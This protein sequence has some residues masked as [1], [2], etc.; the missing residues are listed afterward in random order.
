[1]I[2]NACICI[3]LAILVSCKGETTTTRHIE[4]LSDRELKMLIYRFGVPQGDTIHILPSKKVRISITTSDS[5]NEE[6]PECAARI[7]SAATL[8]TGGGTLTKHIGMN[9]NWEVETEQVNDW[10][11][12]YE[13]S[14]VF[15]IRN[16]DIDE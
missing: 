2:R 5:A 6:A 8:V 4:N 9:R 11:K 14:C 16:T 13:H 1:M 10:P 15:T 12:E 3:L 7:D